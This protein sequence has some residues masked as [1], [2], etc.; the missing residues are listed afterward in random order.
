MVYD[1]IRK[2]AFVH[3]PRSAGT[4]ISLALLPYCTLGAC[5]DMA[6]RRHLPACAMKSIIGPAWD[7]LFKFAVVRP[8]D[9]V[10]ESFGRYVIACRPLLKRKDTLVPGWA[11]LIAKTMDTDNVHEIWRRAHMPPTEEDFLRTYLCDER[12]NDLGI[13]RI[14]YNKLNELWPEI[15]KRI[16]IDPAP[17]LPHANGAAMQ[18]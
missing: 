9:E 16:G 1:L 4:S 11:S 5:W 2:Y 12:G 17:K 10:V 7:G 18:A 13:E 8:F 6:H 15:C 14:P 3:L